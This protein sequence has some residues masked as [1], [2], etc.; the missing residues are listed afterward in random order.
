MSL[1]LPETAVEELLCTNS[2]DVHQK[3]LVILQENMPDGHTINSLAAYLSESL[4][5]YSIH[6]LQLR[7]ESDKGEL[8]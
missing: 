3:A 6:A 8:L 7:A 2:C 5:S 1:N 4:R